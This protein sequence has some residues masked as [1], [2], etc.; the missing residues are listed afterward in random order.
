MDY[1]GIAHYDP[2]VATASNELLLYA[3][4]SNQY[5]V[6]SEGYDLPSENFVAATEHFGEGYNDAEFQETRSVFVD[7]GDRFGVSAVAF[8]QQE[9]LVW[10]GNQG[11]HVTSYYGPGMQK[12]TSFQVH[13]TQEVRHI[14]TFDDGILALTQ[15]A[16]RCQMRRGIP[17]FTHSSDN[18]EEMQCLLQTSPDTL[19]MGG[20][21]EKII[22]FNLTQGQE[23]NVLYVGKNGC[24]ILRQHG[25]FVCAGDPSGRID[26]R[27]PATLNVEHTLEAHSGS[28]SD[29]DVHGNLLVTCGFSNRQG[30]LSVDRFLMVYDLRMMRAVT[31]IQVMLDPL[32]LRFL[33]SFSSRLAIVSTLGQ[34]QLVD[35]VA[36][37]Q[38]NICLYQ[39]NTGGS[40]C[41]AFDVSSSCQCMIFGDA[42]GSLHLYTSN[43]HTAMFNS[44]SRET[45]FADPVEP[46]PPISISDTHI[47]LSSIPLP[48]CQPGTTLLSDWPEEFLKK[49][50]RRTPPIDPEILRTMK[51]QGTIGYAPNPKGCRRN[52]VAYKLEKRGN[53]TQH[54]L[55]GNDSRSGKQENDPL[56]IAIP[57][58]YRK[59][60]VKYSKLGMEDF[61][62]DQYNKTSF[63]GLEATLPN[64]YCNA[65]LQVLYY[66]SAVR[67]V[68]LSHLCQKEFCLACELGFLFHMLDISQGFPC[69]SSNFLRAFRTVP[70]ASALGLILSD[71]NPE[72]KRKANLIRLIQSWN[73]FILHQIHYEILET[74]KRKL[75][76]EQHLNEAQTK[77]YFVYNEQDFP[78]ILDDM[79]SRLSYRHQNQ[80]GQETGDKRKIVQEEEEEG[81]YLW[82]TPSPEAINS[83]GDKPSES[84]DNQDE[85]TDISRLFG[86]K[87]LHIHKC[88]KCTNE[89]CKESIVLLCN[90]SYPDTSSGKA[91]FSFGDVIKRSLCPEQVTPAWCDK[92]EKYQ[93]TLQTRRLKSLPNILAMNCGFDNPRD[94]LFWQSQMD[95]VVQNILDKTGMQ[96]SATKPCRYGANCSRPGCRF[97]HAGRTG[98]SPTTSNSGHLY[99]THS[100]VPMHMQI[101]LSVNGDLKIHR[102]TDP[103]KPQEV[104]EEGTRSMVYDLSAVVCYIHDPQNPEKKNLVALLNVAAEYHE[105]SIGSPVKQWYIFNDFSIAPVPAQE[106]VW[107]SLDWKLPCVLYWVNH[108]LPSNVVPPAQNPLTIDVFGEDKCLARNGGRNMITFTPLAADEMPGRG[109]IVAMDAEFVTL[110]QEE[111]EL[112]SDGKMSFIKP[113]HM[114]VARITC[115]RGQGP[116]EGTAFIDDYIST[117]EQVVDYLTKFS[118]IKPGDLDANFSSKH[119]T[120]LKSTYQK[121]RFLVDNGVTFVGHGL[122]NDFRVINLVVP[123]EQII[124]TVLLFHL[125][126]HRMVSL[127]FL[128]WHFLGIKIQSVT[129][130]SIEDARTALHLYRHYKDMER[131]GSIE[132]MLMEL[133]EVG[134]RLQWKV[135][136]VDDV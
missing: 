86:T 128:A 20:H 135:P 9:E 72:E 99:Y 19:L 12:Y 45:E 14:H 39:I 92:C 24:A 29:F 56:F 18:M 55:F 50:Y 131:K 103:N 10:M 104:T 77:G 109:D 112:R 114:S 74:Q 35:T 66:M 69:Q 91:E 126:H 67:N 25:R 4:G 37:S 21:Q 85:E 87:Q 100:W 105:R 93:P 83:N 31:P 47:P 98:E 8:D 28:L 121:L 41:L 76:E 133:Y 44:F 32:L 2:T 38:P 90:L 116:L 43:P 3:D 119:L 53:R 62:F 95:S 73:R 117:Q 1:A 80:Y 52:Q 125:P 127:R 11:G 36:L 110:N 13:A 5:P 101:D 57:K 7:G 49:V 130:D 61:D 113:S 134:K 58:R 46:L 27:D 78:S 16:L 82:L 40:M 60:D 102:L 107:F 96:N 64:S 79:H 30:N 108:K 68:L 65:M 70:E 71:Q 132:A 97:K 51:M 136:G 81:K 88:V 6:P 123:P 54:K 129:H 23:T 26:L 63:C 115:I 22:E 34:M 89:V 42:G 124:D 33:P 17:I 75:L 111:S 15:N 118:G 84:G 120:T 94:K 106:A 122:K 48:Y 59:I